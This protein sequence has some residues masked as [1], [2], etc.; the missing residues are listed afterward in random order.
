MYYAQLLCC[1]LIN[2]NHENLINC[3][4]YSI[5]QRASEPL[6]VNTLTLVILIDAK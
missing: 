1:S 3:V 2:Y 4:T 5:S 6:N